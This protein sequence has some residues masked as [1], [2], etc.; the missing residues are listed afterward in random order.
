MHKR[1]P[2]SAPPTPGGPICVCV[3]PPRNLSPRRN[4]RVPENVLAVALVALVA[5]LGYGLLL[6]GLFRDLGLFQFCLVIAG[7]QYSLLKVGGAKGSL[8]C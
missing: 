7:C 3:S 1:G 2:P 5:F 4:R 6:R 8:G